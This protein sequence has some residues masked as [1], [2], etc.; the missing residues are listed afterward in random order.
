MPAELTVI[1][2]EWPNPVSSCGQPYT[3]RFQEMFPQIGIP[4]YV[5]FDPN[6]PDITTATATLRRGST[7]LPACVVT[8]ASY[9][10]SDPA[11]QNLGRSILNGYNSLYVVPRDPLTLNATYTLTVTTN[12]GTATT[13][14]RVGNG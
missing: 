10:N 5:A 2:N 12:L 7:S 1:G 8:G 9:T 3:D 11:Q 6:S 13:T 14:V 4:L